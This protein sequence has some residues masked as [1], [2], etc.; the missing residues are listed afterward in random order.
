[1]TEATFDWDAVAGAW[2]YIVRYKKTID[3]WSAWTFDT[4]TT[5]SYGVSGLSSGIYYHWQVKTMCES[6]GI[7]NSGFA[8]Q[9][10]FTTATCNIAL[11]TS[12][13]NVVCNGDA[14]SLIH[15]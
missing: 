15:I 9:V 14:L 13:T 5:N 3:P 7:N 2:G 12:S 11:S 4:V 10:V 6:T 1:M 8:S